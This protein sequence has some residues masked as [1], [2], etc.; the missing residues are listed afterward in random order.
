MQ[1]ITLSARA[2]ELDAAILEAAITAALG[3]L[4]AFLYQRYRKPYLAWWAVAWGLYLLRVGAITSF[5]VTTHR[6]WLYWHQVITGWTA[7]ALLGAALVFSQ[8]VQWRRWYLALVLFPPVWSYIAIYRLDH[9]LWAAG[10]AVL[11]LSLATLWTGWVFA[12]YRRQVASSGATLLSTAFLLWGVHHLD[13]PF[14]RARGTWVP[15]GY[16]LDILLTLVV[17]TGILLLVLDDL[18]RGLSALSALSGDLQHAGREQDVLSVLLARPLTL[19]TVRGSALF[20]IQHGR[21]RLVRGAGVCEQW[22]EADQP[23]E[24]GAGALARAIESGLP[25]VTGKWAY[26]ES[27]YPFAAVLPLLRRDEV[28]GALVLV[29]EARDP[30]T[31]LDDR[32]LVAL[33]QQVG[34]A[35]ENA[36]LYTRLEA[37]TVELARLS[38]RMIEQQEEERR[39][40]SRELH[41]E[42]AQ[43]FSAVKMELGVLRE[44][45]APEQGARLDQV[46]GLIDTGIRSIRSVTNDLRPSI[47]DDLGLL[48]ALRSLVADFSERSGIRTGLAAPGTLPPL[49]EEAE[50]ALFRALQEALSNVLRHAGARTVEVGISVGPT[51]VLLA[52]RDDGRGP[53]TLPPERLEGAGHMGLAGMRERIKALGGSLRFGRAADS[54]GGA[55]LEV[56]VPVGSA[57]SG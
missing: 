8:Q 11:F 6:I 21:L 36:D 15:W 32:F 35:L 43:V 46:L 38:S 19:P 10:P 45:V 27:S 5:L 24:G 25:Q 29:G 4:C 7:L 50:L 56:L 30:F 34:A 22:T 42:T 39:R 16:Y 12:R 55:S 28:M 18:R 1:D 54:G 51:G 3:V 47:L 53:P 14:L 9:F 33:G 40:L 52:V 57:D 2:I 37:R 49:S 13:Y 26:G 41:D 44:A 20:L 31:A 23:G 17:G 48:P